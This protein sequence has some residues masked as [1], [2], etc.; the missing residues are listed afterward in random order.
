MDFGA[1][2]PEINSGRIYSGPGP[3]PMLA[4]AA[5]WAGLATELHS[6]ATA[7]SSAISGLRAVWLGSSSASMVA[8]AAPYIA[9]LSSIAA[10]AEQTAVQA[11]AAAGAYEAVF[12]ATVPPPIIAT[13]R[14]LLASLIATNILGQNTPAI[15]AT[16]AQYAEMWA[17]DA[18]A[19]Y[20]YA[21]SSA[22][23][24]QLTPFTAPPATTSNSG[25]T[26][27]SAAVASTTQSSASSGVQ[28]AVSNAVLQASATTQSGATN[29]A[30]TSTAEATG[31]SLGLSDVT[32][33]LTS[34]NNIFS[35]ATG[36]Y[37]QGGFATVSKSFINLALNIGG[38][39]RALASIAPTLHPGAR[40]GLLAPL[41][42]S[43]LLTG[44][45][46]F[47]SAGGGTVLATAG[48]AGVIG[49]L[50]VPSNWASAVPAVRTVASEL[51][52]TTLDAA[53]AMAANA[54]QGMF[55]PTALS[56][57]AG[58]AIGG[59]ATRAV[60]GTAVRIPGAVAVDD[61]AT[62]STVIVI[63]PNAK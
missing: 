58:R 45:T 19:M 1:L 62:T 51:P 32:G 27:Q 25:E 37:S 33:V 43:D 40:I 38:Q 24:T 30:A 60:A 17:Q 48:R 49:S 47:R 36:A 11:Q 55:G 28:T 20:G 7:Y 22:A 18:A 59:T 44:S 61:I 39:S 23:A 8:A 34:F 42:H 2:P 9:W 15:A 4:A 50:S 31:T 16:E 10:Q 52:E 3:A 63:P 53:P 41:L 5:A 57:L 56:S 14:S 29:A 21:G 13:N 12:A 54:E 6:A 26:N 35:D 46:A